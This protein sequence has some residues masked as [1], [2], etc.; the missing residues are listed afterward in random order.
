[1]RRLGTK[2]IGHFKEEGGVNSDFNECP[3]SR[4]G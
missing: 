3:A 1:M 4:E 2:A